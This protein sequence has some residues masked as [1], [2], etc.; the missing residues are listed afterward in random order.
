MKFIINIKS[1]LLINFFM[2][3]IISGNKKIWKNVNYRVM[4]R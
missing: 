3:K 4:I 2:F 1:M